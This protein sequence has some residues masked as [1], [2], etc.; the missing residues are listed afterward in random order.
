MCSTRAFKSSALKLGRGSSILDRKSTRLNS[1][2]SQISYAVFC[3]KKKNKCIESLPL[4]FELWL[5]CELD[6]PVLDDFY[7]YAHYAVIRSFYIDL[8]RSDV[9]SAYATLVTRS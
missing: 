2:H 6:H 3:L 4:H 7:V 8:Q 9:Y 5:K 1:S